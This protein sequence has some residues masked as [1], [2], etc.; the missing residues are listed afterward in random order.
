MNLSLA[1]EHGETNFSRLEASLATTN[2][3]RRQNSV[4]MKDIHRHGVAEDANVNELNFNFSTASS[5]DA[6][7]DLKSLQDVF[8]AVQYNDHLNNSR[9]FSEQTQIR[10]FEADGTHQSTFWPNCSPWNLIWFYAEWQNLS[11][12][13]LSDVLDVGFIKLFGLFVRLALGFMKLTLFSAANTIYSSGQN[14]YKSKSIESSE[15]S[16]FVSWST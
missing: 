14:A 13:G 10:C 15:A 9:N 5:C 6:L 12:A 3:A 1:P 16:C 11:A 2:V 7:G 8:S 4:E